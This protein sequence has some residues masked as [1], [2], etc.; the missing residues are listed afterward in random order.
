M[1]GPAGK[2]LSPVVESTGTPDGYALGAAYPN[3]F[4][5]EITIEFSVPRDG[6][7]KIEVFNAAGQRLSLLV[8]EALRAGTYKT[9]WNGL[10]SNGMSGVERDLFLPD[11]GWRLC[12]QPFDDPAEVECGPTKDTR[13]T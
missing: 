11:A 4:N 3:P 5:P 9:V 6:P 12:R 10:D 8:D 2:R 13:R 7:V 1:A